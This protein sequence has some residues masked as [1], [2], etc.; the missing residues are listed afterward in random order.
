MFPIRKIGR[1]DP[2]AELQQET[3]MEDVK[4]VIP[5]TFLSL[6]FSL[7]VRFQKPILNWVSVVLK[8]H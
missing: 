1:V 7:H 5:G 8:T 2:Q 4:N 3:E 6:K